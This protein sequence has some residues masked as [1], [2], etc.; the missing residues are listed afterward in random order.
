MKKSSKVMLIFLSTIAIASCGRSNKPVNK[1]QDWTV[2]S[3][4]N[5]E[6]SVRSY[7]RRSG[8]WFFYPF[9]W[10]NMTRQN[11]TRSGNYAPGYFSKKGGFTVG[12]LSV[13]RG[14]FG[15]TSRGGSHS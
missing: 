12:N 2:Q 1:N 7:H 15:S 11:F 5:N 3:S 13:S 14:G 10:H 8:H 4:T 9:I 6:D